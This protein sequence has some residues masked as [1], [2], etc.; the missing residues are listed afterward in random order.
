MVIG[1]AAHTAPPQLASGA[2]IAIEDAIVLAELLLSAPVE[3]A[4]ERFMARRH[5]RCRIVVENSVQL[6]EWE[7]TPEAPGANPTALIQ[8]SMKALAA[9]I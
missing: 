9:P 3:Q 4:L 5:E 6:G 1:D 8:A 2:T 7:K